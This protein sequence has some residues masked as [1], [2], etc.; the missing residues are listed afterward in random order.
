MASSRYG[1]LLCRASNC[2]N[3]CILKD[4]VSVPRILVSHQQTR[5]RKR[6]SAPPSWFVRVKPAQHNQDLTRENRDF[7]KELAVDVFKTSNSPLRDEP[8]PREEYTKRTFRTGVLALKIGVVPQ[9]TTDGQKIFTTMLQ[10][11]DNHVIRYTPPEKLQMSAGWKPWW[12]NKYGVVVVG[13]LSCDPSEFSKDY[14]N[15]F[16]EA[17]VPPKRRLTRFIVTENAKVQ[18]GTPL[19]VM[20][21]RVGD[22][23]DCQAKTVDHGFQGVVK[24]WGFKGQ[25]KS[26]GVTKAHRR[27]GS[28]GGGGDKAGIWKGK[29]MP[30]HMGND[31]KVLKGLRIWRINTKYN[32]LYVQS[33]C[34]PGENHTYVRV[35]DTV[36]PLRKP[37]PDAPPPM[38]TWFPEDS[39]QEVSEE[40]FH[41]KLFNFKSPSIQFEPEEEV[42]KKR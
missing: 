32:I 11:L 12:K 18:P 13:A 39:D 38:P 14:N 41:D 35:M 42:V 20:H 40:Y 16:A 3:K 2:A 37:S 10:V 1:T 24:R 5:G 23:V 7:L 4:T 34:I 29:K 9:W 31:W 22:Y 26:H 30:G 17:G 28:I 15:L 36:L 21:F 33:S 6:T 25:S 19:N 27:M 8:W